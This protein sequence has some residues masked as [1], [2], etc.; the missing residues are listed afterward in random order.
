L[1]GW[2]GRPAAQRSGVLFGAAS[3]LR[4]RRAELA[5]LEVLEAGKPWS[6]ADGDIGEAIDFC[7]YYGRQMLDL[8]A[9]A[10]I[11]SPPGERNRYAYRPKGVVAV[12]SPWN[13]PLAIP[14]GMVAAAL[15]AGNTVVLKPA[16]QTPAIAAA[17]YQALEAGGLPPG[18]LNLLPGA[19]EVVGAHLV[20]N[21]AVAMVAF[22]GSL[23]VGLAIN[24]AAAQRRPGQRAVKRVLAEMGGKNAI[25][26]DGDADLDQA[27]PG[28]V[29]SA[30]GFSGQKCSACSRV[31][32][33]DAVADSLIERLAGAIEG[34]VIGDPVRAETEVGPLIDA[35]AQ[36]KVRGYV[37]AAPGQGR[38]VVDR[39]DVPGE[40]FYV[41]PCLVDRVEPSAPIAREEIFGPV[42][43]VLRVADFDQAMA[44]ANDTD[45]ALTAGIYSRSPVHIALAGSALRAGNIYVNR[46]ITGAIPG[47]H[48]FGGF[49]LS[50]VGAKAGGPDYLLQFLDPWA[51]SENTMRQG[52]A[53]D[54][55]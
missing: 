44:V 41:G 9:G 43:S 32:V 40:G 51:V 5:A 1:A 55:G 10:P 38:V 25:V 54:L 49:G 13:F 31:V 50:G 24:A 39:Q 4:A 48:P 17:L 23:D 36:T 22:T 19:G 45:F 11:E 7:E 3:W 21:P 53:P 18:A 16:E 14:M 12:I 29:Y 35:D 28:I 47:R 33:V 34:V 52:F 46:H 27:V 2:A 42:L 30:F 6:E 20:A 26:V 8:A 37:D 15:V